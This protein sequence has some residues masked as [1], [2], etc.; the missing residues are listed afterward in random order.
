MIDWLKRR[1]RRREKTK[2]EVIREIRGHLMAFGAD[3][4][5]MTDEE[6]E[7]L[8]MRMSEAA[9]HFGVAAEEFAEKITAIH[10]ISR[11]DR[12]VD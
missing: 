5:E 1:F 6:V 12:Y 9:S 7:A 11:L 4:S 3:V 10:R 8:V 2:A